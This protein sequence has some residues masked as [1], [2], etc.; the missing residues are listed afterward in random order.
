MAK[1]K[2]WKTAFRTRYGLFEYTVMPF[3]LTNAAATFQDFINDTPRESLDVFCTAYLDDI[4]IYRDTLKEHKVNVSRVLNTLQKAGILLRP[5][6]C[7]L[8]TQ[9]TIYI[10]LVVSSEGIS[11]DPKKTNA[12][13]EWSIP[14]NVEDL[15]AFLGFAN[16]YSPFIQGFSALATPLFAL[17]KKDTSFL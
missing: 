7:E 16:F 15:Q 4:Q 5:E 14:K 6:K 10:G 1:G 2:Q 12:I 11:M 13:K 17:A 9:K 3:G 8:F